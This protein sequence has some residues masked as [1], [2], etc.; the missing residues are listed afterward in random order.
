MLNSNE[1]RKVS[2]ELMDCLDKGSVK[3]QI[4]FQLEPY[5]IDCRYQTSRTED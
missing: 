2:Y 5:Y 1:E 4:K 3:V